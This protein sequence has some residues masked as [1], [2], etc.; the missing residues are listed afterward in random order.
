MNDVMFFLCLKNINVCGCFCLNKWLREDESELLK[1]M[2][3]TGSGS[4]DGRQHRVT[5]DPWTHVRDSLSINMG[6]DRHPS[7]YFESTRYT[8]MMYI[9]WADTVKVWRSPLVTTVT[10]GQISRPFPFCP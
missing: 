10:K 6:V 2:K 7:P 8:P 5:P 1:K 4:A 9:I 3:N